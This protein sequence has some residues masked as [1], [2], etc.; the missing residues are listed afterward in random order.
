MDDIKDGDYTFDELSPK[1]L[2]LCKDMGDHFNEEETIFP[3]LLKK[4]V[5]I[6]MWKPLEGIIIKSL[7]MKGNALFL[8]WLIDQ[9]Y[10]WGGEKQVNEFF[11]NVPGPIRLMYNTKWR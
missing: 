1:V 10:K 2:K 3:A 8:P 4:Y 6:E 5:T 9:M 7:G 11:P